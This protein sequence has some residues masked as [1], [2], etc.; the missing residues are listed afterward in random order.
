MERMNVTKNECNIYLY[1]HNVA[2]GTH[3]KHSHYM[4]MTAH[5]E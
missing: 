1:N 2:A 3:C 5:N 4:L